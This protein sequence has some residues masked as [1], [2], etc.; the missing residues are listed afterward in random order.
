VVARRRKRRKRRAADHVIEVGV[1]VVVEAAE[2]NEVVVVIERVD[3]PH[4]HDPVVDPVV[5]AERTRVI[6]IDDDL[7]DPRNEEG[8]GA[9]IVMA[10]A[11]EATVVIG[12]AEAVIAG[13]SV[14]L[15]RRKNR[16]STPATCSGTVFNGTQR[17]AIRARQARSRLAQGR[18]PNPKTPQTQIL[19]LSFT[20]LASPVAFPPFISSSR[21]FRHT[22]AKTTFFAGQFPRI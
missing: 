7:L 10:V 13:V 20:V 3:D 21:C 14:R 4:D 19:F 18:H 15:S 12:E 6:V 9:A 11:A 17:L 16:N 22:V 1:V 2:A 8:V 5:Q